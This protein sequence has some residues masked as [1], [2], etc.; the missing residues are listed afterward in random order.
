MI[1]DPAGPLSLDEVADRV[2]HLLLV[3]TDGRYTDDALRDRRLVP[4]LTALVEGQGRLSSLIHS[5]PADEAERVT[6]NAVNL[7]GDIAEPQD[8]EAVQA[9]LGALDHP[10]DRVKLAAATALGQIGVPEA[11]GKILRFAERMM[12]QGQIGTVARLTEALAKIGGEEA[13]TRLAAFVD[14]HRESADKHLQHVVA[15]AEG[16]IR[17]IDER[18]A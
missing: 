16:A 17:S 2:Y 7:L 18:L 9:L 11:A 1:F 6:E 8:S 5:Q 14:Q 3:V 15:K 13:R 12:E 10:S 4:I